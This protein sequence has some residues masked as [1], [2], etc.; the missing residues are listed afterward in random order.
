MGKRLFVVSNRLPVTVVHQDDQYT[1]RQSSGGLISAITAYMAR[2]GRN[3]F[4]DAVWVGVPGC[5]RKHWE[6]ATQQHTPTDYAYHPV[7]IPG[8]LYDGYYNG[9]S[10]SLL[11]P[12]FHYFPSYAEYSEANY[13]Y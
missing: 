11:W 9:F 8:K 12:L 10:N 1:C 6:R 13:E 4:S 2:N 3:R 7:F 5:S